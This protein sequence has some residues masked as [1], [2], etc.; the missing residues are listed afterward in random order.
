MP[1]FSTRWNAFAREA[2]IASRSI[3]SGLNAL[4]TANYAD[5][6][7]YNHAFFGLSI[8]LERLLKLI[9]IINFAIEN[10]RSFPDDEYLRKLGHNIER[11]FAEIRKVDD[12]LP[13]SERRYGFVSGGI[14]DEII[15]FLS[16][17]ATSTRYYNLDFIAGRAQPANSMDPI[18]E[19]SNRIGREILKRH[20]SPKRRERDEQV[21]H[22]MDAL[23][24]PVSSIRHSAEDGTAL[25]TIESA[26]RRTGENKVMQKYG[27]FYCA[28]IVR[29]AY[30]ILYDLESDAHA[31]G[32]D[33]VPYLHEFFFPFLNDD[34]YLKSRKTFPAAG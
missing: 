11:L 23:L 27:T 8:G 5:K 24:S 16:R 18:A 2:G 3:S 13:G 22:A 31:S 34:S 1:P 32:L 26:S 19:W 29:F 9:V 15:A 28:K 25:N 14:E 7:L 33:D 6:G 12:R 4:R 30:M 10:G 20:Y 21:A 17:F